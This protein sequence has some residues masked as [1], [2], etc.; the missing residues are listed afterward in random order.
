MLTR[1][2]RHLII[3]TYPIVL[4]AGCNSLVSSERQS[5]SRKEESN[6]QINEGKRRK[7]R[8][9]RKGNTCVCLA[10][11]LFSSLSLFGAMLP[12]KQF[13]IL[14]KL[15]ICS[16]LSYALLLLSRLFLCLLTPTASQNE[17]ANSMF[18]FNLSIRC[19]LEKRRRKKRQRKESERDWVRKSFSRL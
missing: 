16:P 4:K 5:T 10:S 2:H 9:K 8:T 11:S 19:M 6:E 7:I 17:N 15:N 3:Y 1:A 13:A 18:S 14:S 12:K